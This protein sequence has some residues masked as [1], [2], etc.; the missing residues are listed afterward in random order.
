MF[1]YYD[2]DFFLPVDDKKFELTAM[3]PSLV[4]GPVLGG[5]SCSSMVLI[6][7]ILTRDPPANARIMLG[8]VDVRDVARAHI[9]GMIEPGAAGEYFLCLILFISILYDF[10]K[11]IHP[12]GN[13]D[14]K[15]ALKT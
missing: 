11:R 10:L 4:I 15:K 2:Y 13:F 1:F 12:A 14:I 7:K 8:L 6:R 5:S 3:N 9:N